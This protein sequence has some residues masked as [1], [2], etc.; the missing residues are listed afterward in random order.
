MENFFA[1]LVVEL[2]QHF[3][4][5]EVAVFTFGVVKRVFQDLF[6]DCLLLS[7]VICKL[8]QLFQHHEALLVGGDLRKVIADLLEDVL[9]FLR[10]EV[11]Q[12][13]LQN[14]LARVVFSEHDE[15]VIV[16]Q[17]LLDDLVLLV[18]GDGLD[19]FLD[20]VSAVLV[21][22]NVDQFLSF[23]APQDSDSL[24]IVQL[25]DQVLAEKVAVVV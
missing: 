19:D 16:L 3:G 6:D 12:D 11:T 20:G 5:Y 7:G 17:G 4:D 22:R 14:M 10:R 24:S 8:D 13:F 23:H 21:A 18:L 1:D 2:L 15:I 9:P 25:R